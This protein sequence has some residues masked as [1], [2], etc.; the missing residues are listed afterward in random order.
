MVEIKMLINDFA[1]EVLP[2]Q[3]NTST[4]RKSRIGPDGAESDQYR[5]SGAC[6]ERPRQYA[7]LRSE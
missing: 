6:C 5:R 1:K 4:G 3:Q 7:A 2:E